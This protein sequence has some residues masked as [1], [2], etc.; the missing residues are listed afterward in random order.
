MKSLPVLKYVSVKLAKHSA[1]E[2]LDL[3]DPALERFNLDGRNLSVDSPVI[4]RVPDGRFC[5]R[6]ELLNL[7]NCFYAVMWRIEDDAVFSSLQVGILQ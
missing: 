2:F 6:V 5:R 3:D 1:T 7:H 4:F